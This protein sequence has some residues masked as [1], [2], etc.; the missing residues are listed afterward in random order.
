MR[1]EPFKVGVLNEH[2]KWQNELCEKLRRAG[3]SVYK[4]PIERHSFEISRNEFHDF[5]LVINRASP[6]ANAR[7]HRAALL[8]T[9]QLIDHF[10]RLGI[11]VINGSRAYMLEISKARQCQLFKRLGL[12]F[13]RTIVVNSAE[14][15]LQAARDIGPPLLLKPN[16]GG[17][18]AGV[19]HCDKQ[20]PSLADAERVLD[21]S[22]D[23][24]VLVQE[25][26]KPENETTYRVQ[27]IGT[28]HVYSLKAIG[29]SLNRC[30]QRVDCEPS[31]ES[32][33]PDCNPPEMKFEA[34]LEDDEV[35]EQVRL[36]VREGGFDTCG[37]EYL[38]SEGSRYYF[39]INALSNIVDDPAIVFKQYENFEDPTD[40]L[41]RLIEARL[42]Q[43]RSQAS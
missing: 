13:P 27:M 42:A 15:A 35:L 5:D 19:E 2:S 32:G 3:I 37:V 9:L 26:K 22:A 17:S 25:Y 23:G 8:F 16:I 11:P 21:H 1:V 36:I 34:H 20:E 31:R 38:I 10:E 43:R 14:R 30:P 18:G 7:G 39:D 28:E 4:I 6:S 33:E 41:V 12:P 24:I 29:R 40:R